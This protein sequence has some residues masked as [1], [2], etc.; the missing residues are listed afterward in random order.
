MQ[1]PAMKPG[2]ATTIKPLV[3][4]GSVNADLVLRCQR[5]P[6]PGETVN[7]E[8]FSTLQGGKGANQAVAAARLGAQVGFIG[9]VG[10]DDFGRAARQTLQQEGMDTSHLHTMPGV[11]TGVA[12]ILVEASGQNCIAL[13]PG[14]NAQLTTAHVD[15]AAQMICQAGL[16]VCQL[17]SPLPAVLRAVALARQAGVPV[18]LNP[19]PAQP[20]PAELLAGVDVLVPNESEAAAL[21][22]E[23]S[24]VGFD[25]RGAAAR[26]RALGP[27]IV[28][29]T[30]GAA[31]VQLDDGSHPQHLPA[32]RVQAVDTTG[33]GDT[34]IGAF[35]AARCAG[36]STAY[37]VAFA[38][39]AAAL[40]VTRR[41]AIASMPTRAEVLA[42]AGAPASAP[43]SSHSQ[44]NT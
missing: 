15:A 10:D 43:L 16:L 2:A 38:Q 22:G 30:L 29:V 19:A 20:L 28:L 17:E 8:S 37:A 32:P 1:T 13:S 44:S 26:L 34:F 41:G 35:S 18:L 9:C 24:L 31:G 6:L 4:L 3:V 11:P 33:A 25:A 40:S 27:G 12:M 36:L 5:L 42:A 14:A 39:Q 7:G 21:L 23:T